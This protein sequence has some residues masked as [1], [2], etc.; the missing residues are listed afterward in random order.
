MLKKLILLVIFHLLAISS[1]SNDRKNGIWVRFQEVLVNSGVSQETRVKLIER[2]KNNLKEND[3]ERAELLIK[4]VKIASKMQ[5]KGE[6]QKGEADLT[7][8]DNQ[9]PTNQE[10]V[11]A[12]EPVK[13]QNLG[14]NKDALWA[15]FEKVF[16]SLNWSFDGELRDSTLKAMKT[17]LS[18]NEI[19]L[20]EQILYVLES[21]HN[22]S[23]SSSE[24]EKT[25]SPTKKEN[26]QKATASPAKKL[27]SDTKS[28]SSNKFGSWKDET[29]TLDKIAT[30]V[31]DEVNLNVPP[32]SSD[33]SAVHQLRAALM[34]RK[35][36]SAVILGETGSGKTTLLDRFIYDVTQGKYP[37]IAKD[38]P[39]YRISAASFVGGTRYRGDFEEK[40][41]VIQE[42]ARKR[43]IYLVIDEVHTLIGGGTAMNS[44]NDFFEM[45]LP[46]LASG[47][48][49]V[50]GTSMDEKYYNA[51][52]GRP[53][54]M[55]RM[56]AIHLEPWDNERVKS[57]LVNF[58]HESGFPPLSEN[59]LEHI[60]STS[61][62]FNQTS[63]Q[64]S[65]AIELADD[66]MA[67]VRLYQ[68]KSLESITENHVTEAA[69]R[70]YGFDVSQFSWEKLNERSH[71]L[72]EVLSEALGQENAKEALIHKTK[73]A[74]LELEGKGKP[75]LR[76]ALLGPSGEGKTL[77]AELYAKGMGVPFV[78][79]SMDKYSEESGKSVEDLLREVT[80]AVRKNPFSVLVFDEIEKASHAAQ[81]TLLAA[82]DS[83]KFT[84]TERPIGNGSQG[85]TTV[86]VH[87]H[88]TPI[89]F[90]GNAAAHYNSSMGDLRGYLEAEGKISIPL[91][92]RIEPVFFSPMPEDL[93]AKLVEKLLLQFESR[94]SEKYNKSVTIS[95][96][97]KVV[98]RIL[99]SMKTEI[100]TGVMGFTG[101]SETQA[102]FT[103]P[104]P[105]V[106]AERTKL[107]FE[108]MA[109]SQMDE[110]EGGCKNVLLKLNANP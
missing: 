80:Q 74:V 50:L 9:S 33:E 30:L 56:K 4:T 98:A 94:L 103:S 44:A 100:E 26:G 40:V 109:L 36:G 63:S 38:T 81:N 78:R 60:I 53:D 91:L 7:E 45:L 104:S 65:K 88:N 108:K 97:E 24:E 68:P 75:P 11:N 61:S 46:E 55:R 31:N 18:R 34:K 58:L 82:L 52:G 89:L 93:K 86:T 62:R 106:I 69:S 23:E 102:H 43:P 72:S 41:K 21:R 79:I 110:L 99:D 64:P 54:L 29:L 48:I 14:S 20:A 12:S 15:R 19:P 95:E 66:L 67:S 92:N 6:S 17:A 27:E 10:G 70:L 8:S 5:P 57:A 35:S 83:G 85:S 51:F 71:L 39:F 77:I 49:R 76:L 107:I 1:Y 25:V 84:V 73:A 28:P 3:F 90:T 22:P 13:S 37:E 101:T 2:M 105:R 87:L 47:R 32:E 59:V 42:E 16:E 96:R